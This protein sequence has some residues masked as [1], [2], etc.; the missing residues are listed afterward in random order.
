ML[1]ART[2]ILLEPVT[3]DLGCQSD[4]YIWNELKLKP[5]GTPV[6]DFL[7][8]TTGSRK[9]RPKSGRYLLEK[10]SFTLCSAC[11][12]SPR[13]SLWILLLWHSFSNIQKEKKKFFGIPIQAKDLSRTPANLQCLLTI[14]ETTTRFSVFPACDTHCWTIQT[15]SFKPV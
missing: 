4:Y 14:T 2:D 1:P 6:R 8:Q 15:T 13:A 5:I 9:A 12:H 7:N 3:V 10:G 11:G